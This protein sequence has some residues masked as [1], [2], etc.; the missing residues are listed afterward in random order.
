MGEAEF[1]IRTYIE[2]LKM[3]LSGLPSG[4]I[5]SRIQPNRNNCLSD[6]SCIIWHD[7]KV[8]QDMI[9]RLRNVECGE[10]EIQLQ[11]IDVP[12]SRGIKG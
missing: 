10:I 3:E 9:F 4:T 8:I 7:G 11:W 5:I 2:A 6:E 12:G 1:D